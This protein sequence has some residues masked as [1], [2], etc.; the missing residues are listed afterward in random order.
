MDMYRKWFGIPVGL[1]LLLT[2]CSA[3][4]SAQGM[5]QSSKKA[6]PEV[7]D[8]VF[9]PPELVEYAEA[10]FPPEALVAGLQAEVVAELEIDENGLVDGVN[11]KEPAGH[12][13][14]EAAE[15]AMLRFV[16]APA[17]R[18]GE[19][20]RS[21][22][23]Y[24]YRFFLNAEEPAPED[25]PP[26]ESQLLGTVMT[27]DGEPIAGA[28]LV[29]VSLTATEGDALDTATLQI[30]TD[31]AGKFD[32]PKLP[33]TGYQIDIVASGFK[34]L[35]VTEELED[36]E[37]REVIYRLEAE[38]ATYET[39]VRAKRASRE[40]TRREITRREINRIPGTGGDALKALQNL[41][42]MARAPFGSGLLIVRG[43]SPD[44]SRYFF[45]GMDIPLLYHF[46]G[47]FSIINTDMVEN[48]E[49]Y[50]GNFSVRY[51]GATGGI[52]E[53]YPR[54]P[55]TDR[56]HAYIDANIVHA[57]AFAEMPLGDKWSAAA[58]FRRSYIFEVMSAAMPDN[59]GTGFTVSPR[60]WDYQFVADYHPRAK[61][62]LRFFIFGSDDKM[63]LVTGKDVG[64][65]PTM[66]G[67]LDIRVLS[68]QIQAN[69][70]HKF[71]EGLSN[72]LNLATGFRRQAFGF[73]TIFDVEDN[74]VPVFLREELT[75]DKKR[76]IA[77]RLGVDSA[78]SWYDVSV[79][80]P[81]NTRM[82]EGENQ[83]PLTANEEVT[84]TNNSGLYFRPAIYSE[85]E[86]RPVE[87]LKLIGG[88]RAEYFD[89]DQD[90]VL[91]PRFVGRYE[92]IP[93][94]TI[95]TGIGMF[96][97]SPT[98]FQKDESFGNPD[99][100]PINAI[101]Y[102]L[103]VDQEI[104]TNVEVTLEGFYKDIRN[105][106]V[107]SDDPTERYN[108]DGEGEVWGMELLLKHHPIDRF[109]GWIAYTLMKSRRVDHPGEP[110]R[111]FD[112]DQTHILTV[113][114]TVAIGR[115]WEA[116]VRFRLVSGNPETPIVGSIFDADSDIY[117]PIY[118]K[119]NSGRLPPFHQLD[120]RVDKKWTLKRNIKL[121]VYIEVWN[122]YNR[123]N[124]EAHAY[125]YDYTQRQFF[126]G[127]P[128]L[129]VL[130]LR[131]EY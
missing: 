57:T 28:S 38:E 98:G 131:A 22:I 101:H 5:V 66:S 94:T 71:G 62:N 90:I 51:G 31:A 19:P 20:I 39:V 25:L 23:I 45:D 74:R 87:Q 111:L 107:S 119:T 44:D 60:Y 80:A 59:E 70:E 13:F 127:L 63:G 78:F 113:V 114:G 8:P 54:T 32:L 86:I 69:W 27:M 123:K 4:V 18:D 43:S 126:S 112:F 49:L 110:A 46:G 109:A 122:V 68:H 129:P 124:P 16:F 96:H 82:I 11:I 102:S 88:M 50:P 103:G 116:G 73:G 26:P 42:G 106:V 55:S 47:V 77:F 118:G 89:L 30:T 125:N 33:P 9:T 95:K 35:S 100:L 99:L 92:V 53:V 85:L 24:R 115:G 37:I 91:D 67:D 79:R 97:Q 128:V 14:D 29:L 117:L 121:S 84:E 52:V 108:N 64:D 17:T 6:P 76:N 83:D 130:G 120:I 56:I 1:A 7:K 36:G 21:T 2:L 104:I 34:P 3:M 48:I 75:Y 105:F 93:G 12:G 41:P 10:T 15:A 61:D 58:S 81:I 72:N 40:V 65:N